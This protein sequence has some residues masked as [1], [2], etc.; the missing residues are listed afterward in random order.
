MD[1]GW[2][3]PGLSGWELVVFHGQ[4]TNDAGPGAGAL[5]PTSRSATD[6]LRGPGKSLPLFGP[7]FPIL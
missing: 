1:P 3:C 4:I 7:Q 2:Q 5:L 6:W